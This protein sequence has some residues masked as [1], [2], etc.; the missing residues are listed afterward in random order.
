MDDS[1]VP[2][3]IDP[4][5]A[6]RIEIIVN[7][8]FSIIDGKKV[9][10]KGRT[11]S[12]VVDSEEYAIIELEKDI[13]QYFTWANNQKAIFWVV[14]SR[15]NRTG[16]LATDSQ[17]LDLLRASQVV[18]LFM[19]VGAREEG[20]V[21]GEATND[22]P[23]VVDKGAN[24]APS[25]VDDGT[26][27]AANVIEEE[28]KAEG[29]EWAEVPTY[30]ETTAG[31]P[32]AEEEEK[33]HFMTF[34]CDPHGDEPAGADEE[35][36]YFKKVDAAVRESKAAEKNA[37]EVNKRKRARPIPEFDTE[38]V[39]DDEA[40][41][42]DDYFVPYTTHD[43]EN[44]VIKEKDTF[45]DKEE[46]IQIMRTY[47][48]KNS[49]ETMVEH[50]DKTRYRARCAAE[51]CEWRVYAKKLHG[52]NT[53][54]VVNLSSLD[55][56]TCAG[57]ATLTGHQ[58]STSWIS[59]RAKDIVQEDPTL[60]AKKL[61]KRL[62]TQYKVELSYFKVWAGK[63][64]AMNELHGTWE[65]SFT[66]LWR[67][68]AALQE[69]CPGSIVEIDCKKINGQM[70]FSRM[71]VCIKACV[72]GFLAGC[73]PYLGVDSTHLTG[74][75]NGQLAAATAIDGHN[76][77][78]PVAYGIFGKENNANWAWF[79]RNLKKA[80]GTPPGLTIHSDACKGLAYGVKKAFGHDAEHR[81][82]FRHLMANF[83]KKFKGEVLKY[84]WPCAWACT[85]HRHDALM[86][87]IAADC[88]KAIAFLN[89]HHN[90]IW[91]RSKF[92]KEC[93]I[94]YV[95]NNISECFNNWIKDYKDLPVD[96]LMDKIRQMIQEKMCTRQ[97]IANRL[98]GVILPSV[99]HELNMKSRGLHYEL[100][101]SGPLS[102]E[103]S[104][105]TKEGKTWRYAV[106]LEKRECGC[107]QWEVSG[108]PCPHAIY[109]IGKVRQLK[110]EDFVHD[111]YSVERFKMAYQ[112]KIAP[113]NGRSEW[114]KVDVGFEVIPPPLQRAAG[115]PRKRR[116]KASGEPG[117]RGPYQC[118]RCFQ[119]GH[120]EKGCTATQ[121]ELEQEL[122]PPRPK[123][124]KKARKSKSEDVE[125]S[126]TVVE[127]TLLPHSSPGM[128]TGRATLSPISPGVTTRRMASL[129]PIS[130][131]V[132][133]RRM[134]SLSPTSPG[135]TTRRMAAISPG[136]ISRRI[137]IE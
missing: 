39:H 90:L 21:V 56:H 83:R 51:N 125:A 30:G 115:R 126:T 25:M 58:A 137:I 27:P 94:D 71:F 2:E 116:I 76:W 22:A 62:Q 135:V 5:F 84:M 92:S 70:H 67:F 133:T 34:G 23:N 16:M 63:R 103:I 119:F 75:Y 112:F 88:P 110:N 108:K 3:G 50:S 57:S 122:P 134:A 79:M 31:P 4:K 35:W 26:S 9:Y 60:S 111:Y 15:L 130:P 127:P 41:A 98:E 124:G 59:R 10:T 6:C 128:T 105:T 136:G 73:R 99:L 78:Y 120:I 17:L 123:K 101:K 48:I 87:K 45:G 69:A 13:A 40:G 20:H 52:G 11:V 132:T 96:Y 42:R 64:A 77:M 72:D 1:Q 131:G 100:Q 18:K 121:A 117:K 118:K 114:P 29:F 68:K 65:E 14:D 8:Y 113:M 36:R 7:S 54:M 66:M 95:N 104:G 38:C 55:D 107:G 46:F 82:C 81:E 49:F 37:V 109:L 97:V 43:L 85:T 86:E 102:G 61:Q 80:V 32:M 33:E 53:F 106:D 44:P 24:V 91:S 74:K 93:K 19:T 28:M 12:W 89:K 47:A 129:S